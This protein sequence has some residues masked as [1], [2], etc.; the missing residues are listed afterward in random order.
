MAGKLP[1]PPDC[2]YSAV[3]CQRE[4][5]SV[6]FYWIG[7]KI[8]WFHID[9]KYEETHI[10]DGVFS[11]GRCHYLLIGHCARVPHLLLREVRLRLKSLLGQ[12]RLVSTVFLQ[13]DQNLGCDS[14]STA[15]CSTASS[16]GWPA[17]WLSEPSPAPWTS[18]H[19][20]RWTKSAR[21]PRDT[22]ATSAHKR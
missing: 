18:C 9:S 7:L 4:T 2:S 13:A 1:F 6:P 11:L 14:S 10:T 17:D 20:E 8:Q 15:S 5:K 3:Y 12:S 16:P 19:S 21:H 22:S